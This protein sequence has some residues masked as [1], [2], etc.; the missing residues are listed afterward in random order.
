MKKHEL[1]SLGRRWKRVPGSA[2]RGFF[3]GVRMAESG[4]RSAARGRVLAQ[5]EY[6]ALR[7]ATSTVGRL[8]PQRAVRLG[9]ALGATYGALSARLR[10]RDHRIAMRNLS[11]AFPELCEAERARIVAAM[12]RS[13]GRALA[14][15]A[16]LPNLS[17]AQLREL[18]SLDPPEGAREI[19]A[20]A[21]ETGTLVVT[22]HFGAFELLHAGCAAHGFRIAL[23][24][25]TLLNRRADDWLCGV[26]E[27]FGTRIL[28]RVAAREILRELRAG[29]VV[30][31][32]FDQ[33]ARRSAR[34]DVPFFSRP[35]ATSPGLARLAMISRA[36]VFPVV[37]VREGDS[38]RHRAV[39][40]PPVPLQLS[41]DR[42][43]DVFENTRRF[44]R[45]LEEVIREHPEHWI[46]M[47]GRWKRRPLGS[48][49]NG[50]DEARRHALGSSLDSPVS[51]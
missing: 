36:P 51:T 25:R 27:R 16:R 29:G 21:R 10:L 11:A 15:F 38:P 28:R 13:W 14:D 12:W 8:S 33:R 44:N 6:A 30:A 50:L 9:A 22:A 32:P 26:R 46:W 18:V 40:K 1:N 5:L 39:F 7:L 41:G 34:I 43:A 49:V 35:A 19:F 23:V 3:E 24:Y 45:A 31:V 48:A 17:A 2:I 47:Y 20:R 37:L 4:G 42:E